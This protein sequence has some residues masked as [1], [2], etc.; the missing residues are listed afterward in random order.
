MKN[1][2]WHQNTLDDNPNLKKK[3]E[4][5]EKIFKEWK[6]FKN[7]DEFS[8][9]YSY[10]GKVILKTKKTDI[11]EYTIKQSSTWLLTYA[12]ARCRK[13]TKIVFPRNFIFVR[14]HVIVSA[15]RYHHTHDANTALMSA[16]ELI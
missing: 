9:W 16:N 8:V 1:I 13:L 4:T 5:F 10:G 7:L 15:N 3:V 14:H 11:T 6:S 2:F 12:F